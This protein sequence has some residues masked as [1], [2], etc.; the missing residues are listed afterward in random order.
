MIERLR[1]LNESA[2]L[3]SFF[4]TAEKALYLWFQ[5]EITTHN[6]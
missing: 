6:S 2:L 5:G 3:V 4:E 1:H